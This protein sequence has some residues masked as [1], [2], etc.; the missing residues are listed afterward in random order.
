MSM[1]VNTN[2]REAL[3]LVSDAIWELNRYKQSKELTQLISANEKLEKAIA[4]DPKY[5]RAL[6]YGAMANDLVGK[7]KNAVEKLEKLLRED[8]L[9]RDEVEYNLAVAYYHRYSHRWLKIADEHFEAVINKTGNPTLKLLAHAGLAQ[10][11]AMWIIQPNPEQPDEDEALEHFERSEAEYNLVMKELDELDDLDEGTA[12]EIKWTTSN[13]RGMSLMYYTDY[14]NNRDKKI[15]KLEMA[16]EKL[17][18]ADRYSPKNWANYCDLGSAH[19]RLGYWQEQK[20][21]FDNAL[22]YLE[23]VVVSLRPNYGF[24]LYEI[25]RVYRLMGE[26]EK[27]I[28]Y[29]DKSR[30]IESD[31]RDLSDGTLDREKARAKEESKKFP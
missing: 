24:A 8:L 5:M 7:A 27:A 30:E 28:E 3:S 13:A 19:M 14:F 25:G 29:F 4:L 26:F 21:E 9:S 1:R 12:N 11:H 31:Y 10:T 20:S 16:L 6:F 15:E 2:N 23:E 17:E 22:K 18:E